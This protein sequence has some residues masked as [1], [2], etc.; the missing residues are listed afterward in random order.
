MSSATLAPSSACIRFAPAGFAA[1]H[2]GSTERRSR[3]RAGAQQPLPS[4]ARLGR[5][6]SSGRSPRRG[7]SAVATARLFGNSFLLSWRPLRLPTARGGA[8]S[9]TAGLIVEEGGL[10]LVGRGEAPFDSTGLVTAPLVPLPLSAKQTIVSDVHI[11]SIYAI[12]DSGQR[13]L[14]RA[15]LRPEA[16]FFESSSRELR[17]NKASLSAV[18]RSGRGCFREE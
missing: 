17:S 11:C 9:A 18:Q 2:R 4:C 10:G 3:L 12:T 8:F 13:L 1:R 6:F 15:P 14:E 16:A 5:R 7:H